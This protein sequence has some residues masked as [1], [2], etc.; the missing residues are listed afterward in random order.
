[1]MPKQAVNNIPLRDKITSSS[2]PDN[3]ISIKVTINVPEYVRENI[4]Q[5]KINQIYDILNPKLYK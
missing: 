1:M 4:R 2:V 5:Q 3:D